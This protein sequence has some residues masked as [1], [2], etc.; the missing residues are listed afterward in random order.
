MCI[1]LA[2]RARLGGSLPA[3]LSAPP[4][5]VARMRWIARPS[6]GPIARGLAVPMSSWLLAL[7]GLRSCARKNPPLPSL[8]PEPR[9]M[10][11]ATEH[12]HAMQRLSGGPFAEGADFRSDDK[13]IPIPVPMAFLGL[14]CSRIFPIEA[15]FRISQTVQSSASSVDPRVLSTRLRMPAKSMVSSGGNSH[16]VADFPSAATS[17]SILGCPAKTY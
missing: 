6:L 3:G 8:A 5:A 7:T 4:P 15:R 14:F 12:R 10:V 16:T 9:P 2:L 17:H 11:D 1:V 13:R